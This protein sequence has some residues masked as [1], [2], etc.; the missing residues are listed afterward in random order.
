LR[1]CAA[2]KGI[3]ILAREVVSEKKRQPMLANKW[4]NLFATT[5]I[6]HITR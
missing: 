4:P 5:A 1:I 6:Y 2:A 3:H